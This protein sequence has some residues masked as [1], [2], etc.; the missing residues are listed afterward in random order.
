VQ[1]H[2]PGEGGGRAPL[3]PAYRA[4][5]FATGQ[6]ITL[7]TCSPDAAFAIG[8]A[9]ILLLACIHTVFCYNIH[10]LILS[11]HFP[12]NFQELKEQEDFCHLFEEYLI[13][14]SQ[15]M[16]FEHLEPSPENLAKWTQF[17]KMFKDRHKVG[18]EIW[19][20]WI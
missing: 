19:K 14:Y 5:A 6:P 7:F 17:L 16:E 2:A 8:K 18:S 11:L 13:S 20:I 1:L 9:A 12:F 4:S 15:L 10:Y 3:S